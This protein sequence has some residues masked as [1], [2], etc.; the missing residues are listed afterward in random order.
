MDKKAGFNTR[1][2]HSGERVI[3]RAVSQ[4]IFQTSTYIFEGEAQYLDVKYGRLNNTPNHQAL[5]EKI[6]DLEKTEDALVT[7]SGMAAITSAL[8]GA[9][10]S[11]GHLLAQDNLYG[12]T[13][14]FLQDDFPHWGRD[15]SLFPTEESS[16][17]E[18]HLRKNTKAI[19]VETISNPLLKIPDLEKIVSVAHKHG[20]LAI[21]DNTFACPYNFNPTDLGFDIVLHSATKYL[22]GHTDVL[23]G[24]V[25]GSKER[26]KEIRKLV[27]HLG[28]T[29]DPHACF[30]LNRGIKTLG[31]RVREHNKN[32]LELARFLQGL[33]RV[34]RVYYPG[35]EDHPDHARA[36]KYLRGFGGMVS[37]DFR[38]TPD[39]LEMALSRLRLPFIAPSLGGI[40]SLITRPSTTSHSG[41]SPEERTRLGI[42]DTLV[43]LSVGLEDLSDLKDDFQA[44][45][46]A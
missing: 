19:Y 33:K 22:N 42:K 15:V 29:L 3:E 31:L 39:E 23:A 28:P 4:P 32:A 38:G 21:I 6:A 27:C 25:A 30:L 5:Q 24:V 44:A 13:Y 34:E 7:A 41:I 17:V 8:L 35:L 43:R 1:A 9:I 16:S 26:L 20:A 18:K 36:K 11:G 12:G 45:F 2:I 46:N 10:Q 40:E 37:F 14:Y